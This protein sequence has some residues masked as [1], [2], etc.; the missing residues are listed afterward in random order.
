MVLSDVGGANLY[1]EQF[2]QLDEA[3]FKERLQ[4]A[5]RA[6]LEPGIEPADVNPRNYHIVG[7]AGFVIDLEDTVQADPE[8]VEEP[9]DAVPEAVAH[10]AVFYHRNNGSR[11]APV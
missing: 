6:M 9:A 11:A 4:P 3:A 7:D 8:R 5:I 1:A 10:W 2:R